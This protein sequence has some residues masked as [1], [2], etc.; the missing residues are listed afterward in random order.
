MPGSRAFLSIAIQPFSIAC[1]AMTIGST[2]RRLLSVRYAGTPMEVGAGTPYGSQAREKNVWLRLAFTVL[3][4]LMLP[5]TT[6]LRLTRWA[7]QADDHRGD[8]VLWA[9]HPW[10]AAA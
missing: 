2:T 6:S 10:G 8:K 3:S 4:A 5:A 1:S 7:K 9:I